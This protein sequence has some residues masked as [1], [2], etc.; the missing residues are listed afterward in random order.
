MS[1]QPRAHLFSSSS[2][3]TG[4]TL[5]HCL[6]EYS[7]E[8]TL[9]SGNEWYCSV[10]KKHQTPIKSVKF[11]RERL[12]HVLIIVLKRFE[13]RDVGGLVGR[14]AQKGEYTYRDKMDHFVDFPLEGLDMAPYC[15]ASVEESS[16]STLY[17]LFAVCNHYGRMGFGHYTAFARDWFGEQLSPHWHSFDDD[18]VRPISSDEVKTQAAYVLFYRKRP[19]SS[20]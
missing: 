11:A 2:S 9:D 10:C 16:G 7:R 5:E 3:T 8:E 13:F 6:T 19:G 12:P 20:F 18:I 15:A 4:I 14:G 1:V 17:D